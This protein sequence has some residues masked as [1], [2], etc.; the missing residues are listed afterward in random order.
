MKA[1]GFIWLLESEDV[2]FLYKWYPKPELA[3][4]SVHLTGHW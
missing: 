3:V 1:S 4:V 2:K